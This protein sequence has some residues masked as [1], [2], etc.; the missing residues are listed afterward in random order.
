[1]LRSWH[2]TMM[3]VTLFLATLSLPNSKLMAQSAMPSDESDSAEAMAGQTQERLPAILP[4]SIKNELQTLVEFSFFL[5][6]KSQY[7]PISLKEASDSYK[8]AVEATKA[9][10][11]KAEKADQKELYDNFNRLMD[12]YAFFIKTDFS[13]PNE[14]R[15]EFLRKSIYQ[16]GEWVYLKEY[17]EK[18]RAEV[19]MFY[20]AAGLGRPA[21][22]QEA[23]QELIAMQK[24]ISSRFRPSLDLLIYHQLNS[25]DNTSDMAKTALER[26]Y[27]AMRRYEKTIVAM[28]AARR[29]AGLQGDNKVGEPKENIFEKLLSLSQMAMKVRYAGVRDRIT[30]TILDTWARI[31][32][33]LNWQKVPLY[34]VVKDNKRLSDPLR[35][36]Y[37]LESVRTGNLAA[38]IKTY[39]LFSNRYEKDELVAKIDL[40]L[41]ELQKMYAASHNNVDSLQ[42]TYLALIQKYR[43]PEHLDKNFAKK[44]YFRLFKDYQ[45]FVLDELATAQ[46]PNANNAYRGRAIALSRKFIEIFGKHRAAVF[47]VKERLATVYSLVGMAREATA[48]N[49]ELA[50]QKP[51]VYLAKA[52]QSQMV[53]AKWPQ[54]PPWTGMQQDALEERVKLIKIF[55]S[56]LAIEEKSQKLTWS[57][58]GHLGLLYQNTGFPQ[59]MEQLWT[60]YLSTAQPASEGH[61]AFGILLSNY[62]NTAKWN[63]FIELAKMVEQKSIAPTV[64]GKPINVEAL[65]QVAILKRAQESQKAGKLDQAM[66]DYVEFVRRYP[67]D[68]RRPAAIY[69]AAFLQKQ[70]G[71]V[72]DA[73]QSVSLLVSEYPNLPLTKKAMFETGSWVGEK[74]DATLQASVANFLKL[75]VDNF[76]SDPA[77]PQARYQ[78]AQIYLRLNRLSDA[79]Q[80]FRAHAFDQRVAQKERVSAALAYIRLETEVGE[81]AKAM[82]ESEP[83]LKLADRSQEHDYVS[84]H[85]VLARLATEKMDIQQMTRE[86]AILQAYGKSRK[87]VA[88]TLGFL[89]LTKAE[90]MELEI[91]FPQDRQTIKTYKPT[92]EIIYK[93]FVEI[94]KLY[95]AVC[96]DGDNSYCHRA[97][98]RT[99]QFAQDAMDAIG[100]LMV[101]DR[102]TEKMVTHLKSFQATYIKKLK[103][104]YT[105]YEKQAEKYEDYQANPDA[106]IIAAH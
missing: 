83:I 55:E 56:L 64:G 38:A 59:K 47:P 6:R 74:D 60:K 82:A 9:V 98:L 80:L 18:K 69:Q 48:L 73:L 52:A 33:P 100:N 8:Q 53:L 17:D 34:E 71:K 15:I 102:V 106:G 94:S 96:K 23:V 11:A 37:V 27:K 58:L 16:I 51:E 67:Q 28:I 81:L 90:G 72:N 88:E 25:A 105:Y 20:L 66:A 86:E 79:S 30:S 4:L 43:R 78:L 84:A 19:R 93:K 36:R 50:K 32:D 2:I 103:E 70:Q 14:Q 31:T 63:D 76:Q 89:R 7:F 65:Y 45:S 101:D 22:A 87:D 44:V 99:K 3:T 35:E 42:A 62:Y 12:L 57:T 46:E 104:F 95:D 39:Q 92:I 5:K 49:L 21:Y 10:L 75:F 68:K 77:L 41:L 29:D 61:A 91:P 1:M 26:S 97:F 40:R 24:D 54:Q 13:E 85:I